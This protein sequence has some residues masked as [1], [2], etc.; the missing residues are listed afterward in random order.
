MKDLVF[1]IVIVV[2]C[3]VSFI[4]G[5]ATGKDV[6]TQRIQTQCAMYGTG[7]FYSHKTEDFVYFTSEEVIKKHKKGNH[8]EREK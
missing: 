6:T 8:H 4:V 7:E 5:F 1:P 3:T 2:F